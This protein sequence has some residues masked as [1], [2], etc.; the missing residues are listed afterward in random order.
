MTPKGKNLL[1]IAIAG[2]TFLLDQITKL[3]IVK[4][5]A[6]YQTIPVIPGFFN[7]T[8]VHNPGGAFGF[9]AGQT[10]GIRAMVF[11]VISILAAC[12]ILYLYKKTDAGYPFLLASLALI[13]G[14]ALGNLADR[15]RFGEVIDFLDF[16]IQAVHYPAFNVADSA[17][18]VG[19]T[20]LIYHILFKKI[21][22]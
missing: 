3:V 10:H 4:T 6:L 11:L 1:L 5:M 7:I 17:I 14:G 12:F 18:C 21:P 13:F 15:I 8:R 19:M 9:M 20:V 22:M 16:Y 2:G